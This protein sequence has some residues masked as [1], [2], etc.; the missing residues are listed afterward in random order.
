MAM[1]FMVACLLVAMQATIGANTQTRKRKNAVG[2]LAETARQKS[3]KTVTN[4][5]I[6]WKKIGIACHLACHDPLGNENATTRR[7]PHLIAS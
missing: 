6:P 3:G 5:A 2:Q 4:G 7:L 1:V